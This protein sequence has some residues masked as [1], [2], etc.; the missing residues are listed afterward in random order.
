[1]PSRLTS[2]SRLLGL[3]SAARAWDHP[4]SAPDP[5]ARMFGELHRELATALQGP[6]LVAAAPRLARAPRAPQPGHV[7]VDVPG[8]RAPEVAT[9]PLRTYLRALGYDAHGWGFGINRGD[10]RAD[11][12]RLGQQVAGLAE[13]HGPVSL[14]GWS[15]G[16]VIVR[17]V[18]RL[19]PS[20]VACVV[21]YGSPVFGGPVPKAVPVTAIVSRR[22]GIVPWRS[23]VDGR[24]PDVEHV[25][26]DSTHLGLGFDPDV[27]GVVA[28]RLARASRAG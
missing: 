14:V 24:S 3:S 9:L 28:E 20:Y 16:G 11:A 4:A 10:A 19:H 27:W 26:V 5:D 12:R 22:D 8:W 13:Q 25:E 7:V 17:E 23:A 21:T 1:M 2:A 18:A 6:R 15:L